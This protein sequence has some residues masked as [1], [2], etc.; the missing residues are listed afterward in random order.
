MTEEN[1]G[2]K[3]TLNFNS[4]VGQLFAKPRGYFICPV[5]SNFM[6]VQAIVTNILH[7]KTICDKCGFKYD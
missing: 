6:N 1:I 4:F 7:P 3:T 5:C 2:P